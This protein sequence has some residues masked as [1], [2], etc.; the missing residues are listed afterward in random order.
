MAR[1]G[2]KEIQVFYRKRVANPNANPFIAAVGNR[3][4]DGR[5]ESA[6]AFIE[7]TLLTS[8]WRA[9]HIAWGGA[10]SL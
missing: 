1:R 9:R 10:G 3:P 5:L 7:R 2:N 6:Y 8:A 4:T